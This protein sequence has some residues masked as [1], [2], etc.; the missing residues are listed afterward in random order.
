MV[1][2]GAIWTIFCLYSSQGAGKTILDPIPDVATP[3]PYRSYAD[4]I[5]TVKTPH[6]SCRS[7]LFGF[8][9]GIYKNGR[10]RSVNYMFTPKKYL[11]FLM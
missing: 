11:V 2:F 5:C 8:T 10:K 1:S 6:A 4:R 9:S 3:M 7:P